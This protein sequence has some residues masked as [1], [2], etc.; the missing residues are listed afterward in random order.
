LRPAWL[1]VAS[2]LSEEQTDIRKKGRL[3]NV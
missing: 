3:I 1:C 2:V